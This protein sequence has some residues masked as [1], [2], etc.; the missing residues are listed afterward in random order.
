MNPREPW[1]LKLLKEQLDDDHQRVKIK[2]ALCGNMIAANQAD[3]FIALVREALD[4]ELKTP[5][6]GPCA[7]CDMGRHRYLGPIHSDPFHIVFEEV[8]PCTKQG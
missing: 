2:L 6:P 5:A 7:H 4:R 1:L 8:F 3:L